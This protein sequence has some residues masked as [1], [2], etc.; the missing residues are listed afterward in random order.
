M[1]NKVTLG[2]ERLGSGSKM[3]VELHGY[4]RSSHDLGYLW[5]ST[6][7][8]GTLVPFLSEVAL[9]GDTFDIHLDADIKTHPT[10]GP[11]FGSYKV[12]LDVFH[13]PIRLYQ[14]QLH[15]NKL[16]IGMHMANIKLPTMRLAA[17]KQNSATDGDNY[18]INPS[19]VLAYL[20]L[21]GVGK[22]QNGDTDEIGVRTFNALPL[23]A[24]WDIY[25]NYY[26]NKQE[27]VGAVIHKEVNTLIASVDTITIN[28]ANLPQDTGGV[29]V[30]LGGGA[31]QIIVNWTGT[32][33][34]L[35]Q[36]LIYTTSGLVPIQS[37]AGSTVVD[38][39][40][41]TTIILYNNSLGLVQAIF[42][43]YL[44]Q[45]Q[46]PQTLAPIVETF[47]LE[48]IDK[49]R[50]NIL[51]FAT[52]GT[53]PWNLNDDNGNLPPYEWLI[54]TVDA[55]QPPMANGQEG[56]A[57]K[58]YQSDLFN[59]WLSTEWI[60]GAEGISAV[61][62][63]DTTGGSFTIDTLNLSKKVYNMLNRIAV[64]GG[65]YDDW[66]DAVYDHNR[67]QRAETPVYHGGLIRE[68]VFNEVVSNSSSDNDSSG[69][70]PLGTLAGK[71]IMTSKRKGGSV[72]IK[73]DEPSYI[74]GII[75]ITP[76]LDYSQGNKWDMHLETMDDLHK[77]AL[78]EIG[79]QELI[80]EQMAWWSTEK[81]NGVDE[82]VTKSA[83]KQP[84]WINYMTNVNQTRG[85]FAIQDNE[86][87][88]T[89]NRRYESVNSPG[90]I[91]DLTTYIDPVKFNQIF[92]HTAIDA[93]NF[94]AQ[95][96]VDITAR[97]KMSAK[98]MPNL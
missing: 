14:G 77:P 80:T 46:I 95:I 47:D 25:K 61:T 86:M 21:R 1:P 44:A 51:T 16:G 54:N 91:S 93:Q 28:G 55:T 15:N 53:D 65:S 88:M 37:L 40:G 75:S 29:P 69:A 41:T 20:G 76:R 49:T 58:T 85:N 96:A 60:D 5:R 64:S 94:W 59:N 23:L 31:N 4:E 71:G 97:R 50:E 90:T 74:M 87:F 38:T 56:L 24:Y 63:I 84:A 3:K 70:Q 45:S 6:M 48:N 78:D 98:I 83:G 32:A 43:Q 7:S 2:G 8:A 18:Q 42:W 10:I 36:I 82:W 11:L 68:L 52:A 22:I 81:T 13:A 35:N 26:A 66:L 30:Q 72:T 12:Q 89:L 73:I 27:E 33:P 79:F 92:A 17:V 67:I 34:D 57:I 39:T 9:P 62:A 19:C